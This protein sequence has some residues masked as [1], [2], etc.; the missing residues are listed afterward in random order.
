MCTSQ[1]I[2][3]H[4]GGEDPIVKLPLEVKIWLWKGLKQFWKVLPWKDI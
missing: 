1:Q 4:A 3:V 2:A